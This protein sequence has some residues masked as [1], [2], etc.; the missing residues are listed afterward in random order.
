[1]MAEDRSALFCD[2]A[3]TYGL[4]TWEGIPARTLA[5]LAAGLRENSRIHKKVTGEK[6]SLEVILLAQ[7]VDGINSLIWGRGMLEEKPD[8]VLS[9]LTGKEEPKQIRG[10]DTADEFKKAW[11]KITGWKR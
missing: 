2:L 5:T 1:M 3:E 4:Y 11:E 6:H 10:F 8:S 9:V 7:I